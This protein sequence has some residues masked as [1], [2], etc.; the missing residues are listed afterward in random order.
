MVDS[1]AG[2]GRDRDDLGFGVAQMDVPFTAF[3]VEIKVGHHVH[4]VD[5]DEVADG[6]HEGVLEG[7][8]VAFGHGEDHRVTGR[9]GVELGRA[10]EVADILKDDEVRLFEVEVIESLAGHLRIEMAHAA[11]VQLDG[12]HTG[13]LLD[14]HRIHIA[15][16]VSFHH[17]HAHLVLDAVQQL[18]EGGGLATAGCGHQVEEENTPGPQLVPKIV[19]VFFVLRKDALFDFNNLYFIHLYNSLFW[20]QR[21]NFFAMNRRMPNVKYRSALCLSIGQLSI[22]N[23]LHIVSY[24][25]KC[26]FATVFLPDFGY[27]VSRSMETFKQTVK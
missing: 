16:D 25:K 14:F 17:R 6:E 4:L 24:I 27:S 20:V 22:A 13:L 3:D 21:Y 7:F 9:A 19:G 5:D 26:T 11:G 15:V 8:V 10:N 18:D 23:I 1:V 12:R 2:F